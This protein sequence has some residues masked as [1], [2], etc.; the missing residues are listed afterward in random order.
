MTFD[1]KTV[2]DINIEFDV[3]WDLYDKKIGSKSK[4]VKKWESLNE[5][6]F[7]IHNGWW[8]EIKH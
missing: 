2:K 6:V 8:G 4:C 1:K 7:L 5:K 3:F